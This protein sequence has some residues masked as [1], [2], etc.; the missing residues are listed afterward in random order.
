MDIVTGGAGFIGSHLSEFLLRRGRRVRIVDNFST[1]KKT[2]VAPL[3]EEFPGH[4]AVHDQDISNL[5]EL[6]RLFDGAEIVYHQAA[7]TS[8]PQSV[9]DPLGCNRTN[10]VGTL[11]VLWAA[12]E[13]GARKVVFA[14]STAV[15]GDSEVLPKRED[16]EID[17]VSPYAATKYMGEVYCRLFSRMYNV[18]TLALRYFNVFGPRQDPQSQYAAVIPRFIARMLAGEQP[19]IYGDGEQSRD[20]VFVE[21]VVTANVLAAESKAHGTAVNIAYGQRF[22]LNQLV[23]MLGKSLGRSFKP[24]YEAPRAGDIRHSEAD[25]SRAR[26]LLGF[27]PKIS[28]PEGLE[29]TGEWFRKQLKGA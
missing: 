7:M 11:K 19:T 24:I 3:L 25:V 27:R 13:A 12:R 8:V 1:G 28:L 17:P 14:S 22:T 6:K 5:E 29:R 21:D 10:T 4:C 23:E 20:F 16:M 2:N 9:E 18:P 15:Y 26:E